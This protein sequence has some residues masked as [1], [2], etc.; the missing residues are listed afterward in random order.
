MVR[1]GLNPSWDAT[2]PF[3]QSLGSFGM[4]TCWQYFNATSTAGLVTDSFGV[5]MH[6]I[7]IPVD[8]SL[9]GLILFSQYYVTDP[10][11]NAA[12]IVSTN[13]GRIQPGL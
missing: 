3:P 9:S 13:M 2:A 12:Q 6:S 7:A 1:D 4:P 8:P 11:A 10:A 5:A